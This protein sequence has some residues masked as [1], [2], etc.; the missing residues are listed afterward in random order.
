MPSRR[1]RSP[2]CRRRRAHRQPGLPRQRRA[3]PPAPPALRCEWWWLSKWVGSRLM[4]SRKRSSW[5]R[6]S[7]STSAASAPPRPSGFAGSRPAASTRLGI[8]SAG[9]AVG[10][11]VRATCRPMPSRGLAAREPRHVERGRVVHHQR[12]AGHDAAS[13]GLEDALVDAGRA[14]EVVRVHDQALRCSWASSGGRGPGPRRR[15]PAP[16]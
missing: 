7:A 3:A 15:A 13:V 14:A 10:P 12:G 11:P 6:A 1:S 5:A 16:R 4:I 2:T 9:S 8:R